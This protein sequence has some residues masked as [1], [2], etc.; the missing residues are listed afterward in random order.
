MAITMT[1]AASKWFRDE[2]ALPAGAGI[3]FFGKVYGKTNVHDG[4]SVGMTRDDKPAEVV[5]DFL[6]DGI[7]YYVTAGDAWFFNG[8]DMAVD[9]DAHRDEPVYTFSEQG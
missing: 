1:D 4:F 6:K 2:L 3:R 9:Y 5:E 7:H 8:L